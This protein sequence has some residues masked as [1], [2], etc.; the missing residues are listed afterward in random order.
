MKVRLTSRAY[1]DLENITTYIAEENHN[2]RA[3]W[4]VIKHIEMAF[5]RIGVPGTQ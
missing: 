3:A 2:P 4:S 1:N 5:E